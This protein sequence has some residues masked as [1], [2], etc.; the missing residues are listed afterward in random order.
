MP[1]DKH[2]SPW[3]FK[4][5]SDIETIE[6]ELYSSK[7]YQLVDE[8]T[9]DPNGLSPFDGSFTEQLH[10]H[11]MADL[12]NSEG[13]APMI[14]RL[15]QRI[16]TLAS[17]DVD[18]ASNGPPSFAAEGVIFSHWQYDDDIPWW[19]HHYWLA[20]ADI[21]A[22]GFIQAWGSFQKSLALVVPRVSLVSQCY[23]EYLRQPYLILKKSADIAYFRA[24]ADSG[25]CPL[26]FMEAE[27]KALDLLLKYPQIPN[28][29]FYYWN[30]AT[31]ANGYSSK[32]LLMI[33]ALEALTK[34]TT[35][36]DLK[37]DLWGIKGDSDDALRNRLVH[38]EYF[39][40]QDGGKN[41]VELI[42]SKVITYFNESILGQEL[43][44]KNVVNPQRHP[45]DKNQ[46]W[47]FIKARGG[48]PLSLVD[49]MHD[50]ERNENNVNNLENYQCV[51][52]DGLSKNY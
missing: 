28:E 35:S 29:F 48:A 3:D 30:D 41:Y 15:E 22:N 43:L 33:V 40:D 1:E 45:S 38:G 20:T 7:E 11:C 9:G 31:N 16:H 23:T 21:E 13:Q 32:L 10:M 50:L 51:I 37:E 25:P 36:E 18:N 52:D 26:S 14:Y 2:F 49:V 34:K 39:K 6:A 12:Q 8:L 5:D 47:G 19:T 46:T 24:I 44:Q 4:F 42:H 27:K 17:N